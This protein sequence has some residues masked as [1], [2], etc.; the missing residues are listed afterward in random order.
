MLSITNR[1]K[2]GESHLKLFNP[3]STD[4]VPALAR[5]SHR[6]MVEDWRCDGSN[7]DNTPHTDDT[8]PAVVGKGR[9]GTF[10]NH[11]VLLL[12]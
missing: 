1:G 3:L 8:S 9:T 10:K 2:G 12:N 5:H 6:V 4:I 7:G 11:N